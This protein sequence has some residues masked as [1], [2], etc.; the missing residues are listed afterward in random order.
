MATETAQA[1]LRPQFRNIHVTQLASY[2]LPPA[3]VLSILHRVSGALLFLMLP[4]L[5]WLFEASLTS[6]GTF[7]RFRA[8]T[9]GW[10]GRGGLLI[11]IWAILHHLFAG[12]RFLALDL[13]WGIEKDQARRSAFAVFAVSL[14]LTALVAARLFGVI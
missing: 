8:V 11:V 3:G 5:L 4:A 14:A 9:S 2:R 7:E 6:E 12:I 1:R 10:M 13:H